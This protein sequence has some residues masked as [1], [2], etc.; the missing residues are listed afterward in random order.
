MEVANTLALHDTAIISAMKSFIVQAVS[1]MFLRNALAYSRSRFKFFY[2]I[3]IKWQAIVG[4]KYEASS[5]GQ[6][7][8]TFYDRNLRIFVCSTLG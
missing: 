2:L 3:D 7:Y 4:I 1:K 6:C 5:R 8:K